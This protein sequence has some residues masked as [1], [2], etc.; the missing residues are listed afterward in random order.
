MTIELKIPEAGESIEEVRIV[1]WFKHE[2]DAVEEDENLVELETDKASMALAAPSSGTLA[3]VLKGEGESASVGEV[4]ARLDESGAG[5]QAQA[6]KKQKAPTKK[7]GQK[8]NE[9]RE[10]DVTDGA[11]ATQQDEREKDERESQESTRPEED[12]AQIA[13]TP[14]GRREL[15]KHGLTPEDVEPAGDRIRREDVRQTVDAGRADGEPAASK[16]KAA[17]V[18]EDDLTEV[19]PMTPIRRRIAER[20]VQAQQKSALLTTFNQVDMLAVMELRQR[21]RE[22]FQDEYEVDLGYM[23]FFVKATVDALKHFPAIN[24]EVRGDDIVYRNYY[25]IGIAVGSDRGLVVPVLRY[26]E[27]MSFAEIE[28]AIDDFAKRAD[29]GRL[30]PQELQGGTFTI[31]NGGVYGSLLSTPIVNPP[32]SGVLG[33]H[34]I[35]DRPVARNGEVVIRPM[36][37]VALS[38]DHRIVD[39]REAVLFLRRIREAIEEPARML[40]EV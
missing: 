38:Y 18:T 11:K 22:R 36:M 15:R 13:V 2:G 23:S 40:I 10:E 34:L 33:M 29:E 31:S 7:K 17:D 35:E 30:E 37:Y 8:R 21:H 28:A 26:A 9:D 24:A 1:E 25:H 20:L 16:H 39:G 5:D 19:V 12:N 4:I 27:R 3:E 14:S 6:R 32:Q